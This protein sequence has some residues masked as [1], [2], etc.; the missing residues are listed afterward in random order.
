MLVH[1]FIAVHLF[2]DEPLCTCSCFLT[3][4]IFSIQR[5]F[6]SLTDNRIQIADEL[7]DYLCPSFFVVASRQ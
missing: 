4:A 7:S 1:I 5:S 3:F 6:Y 2:I